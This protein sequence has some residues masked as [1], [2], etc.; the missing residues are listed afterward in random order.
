MS[1]TAGDNQNG[2]APAVAERI[3]RLALERGPLPADVVLEEALYGDGGFYASGRGAGRG[4]DFLTSPEVGPLFGAVLAR[5]L[6][7][8][9]RGLGEPDPFVVVEGGAGDGTL[10][11]SVLA[12]APRCAAALRWVC[13]E[14]SPALRAA[15]DAALVVE[16]LTQV[17][18]APRGSG[19][20]VALAD[21]LPS[22]PFVGAVIVNELL[23]N[24]PPSIVERTAAGWAEVRVDHELHEVLVPDEGLSKTASR[25][26]PGAAVGTRIPILRRAC[27]WVASARAMLEAGPVVCFD[28]GVRTTVELA[29]RPQEEWLRTYR[30]HGRGGGWLDDLGEQD[31]TCDVPADQLGA[32]E[33]VTQAEWLQGHGLDELVADARERWHS[34]AHIGDLAALKARSRVNEAAALTDP[35]GLGGFFVH[36]WR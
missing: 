24:L 35:D 22:G 25:L 11:R 33:V 32:D 12:A 16:P 23:D 10:V 26:A 29:E 19:P 13:V 6:D 3:R 31:V 20:V 34:T 2:D 14:R 15:A 5:A 30:A 21:D 18:G 36:T 9:W 7:T 8:W 17:L 28:Y 4:R 27:R 1:T